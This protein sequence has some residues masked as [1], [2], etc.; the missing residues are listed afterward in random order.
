MYIYIYFYVYVYV[1]FILGF[2]KQFQWANSLNFSILSGVLSCVPL[3]VLFV[4]VTLLGHTTNS[5]LLTFQ[6]FPVLFK[7]TSVSIFCILFSYLFHHQRILCIDYE[8]F[9]V[10]FL[11]SIYNIVYLLRCT[12]LCFFH[13]TL[14]VQ[15][16]SLVLRKKNPNTEFFLVRIFSNSVQIRKIWTRKNSVFEHFSHCGVLFDITINDFFIV[17]VVHFFYLLRS[18]L[19]IT[20]KA[21]MLVT[22][23][24]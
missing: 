10:V 21:S 11:Y 22:N 14:I 23:Q 17:I 19:S 13:G 2:K 9:F 4:V 7:H 12:F 1:Y 15:S 18:E 8:P 20:S 5:I 3:F 24:K 6:F 16:Q